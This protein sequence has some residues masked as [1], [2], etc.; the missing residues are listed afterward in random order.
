MSDQTTVQPQPIR[1]A[2]Y[3]C[4]DPMTRVTK[5]P[6]LR[7]CRINL[8]GST[9]PM[10]VRNTLP[11]CAAHLCHLRSRELN[12][13]VTDL[14]LRAG[15]SIRR[16]VEKGHLRGCDEHPH[17]VWYHLQGAGFTEMELKFLEI[18]P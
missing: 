17:S 5:E 16:A 10:G 18:L 2:C 13:E 3:F 8:R 11:L 15:L 4:G 7:L 1:P 9:L 6:V 12:E 14:W